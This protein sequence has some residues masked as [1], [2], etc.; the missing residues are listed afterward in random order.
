MIIFGL[1]V[2]A[3]FLFLMVF[4]PAH[5]ARDLIVNIWISVPFAMLILQLIFDRNRSAQEKDPKAIYPIFWGKL[6]AFQT[7]QW[8]SKLLLVLVALILP[9]VVINLLQL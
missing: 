5:T 6:V 8:T 7:L 2:V 3:V 4:L 9:I 1:V